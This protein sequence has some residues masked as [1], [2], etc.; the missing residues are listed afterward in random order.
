MGYPMTYQRVL[1]RN[2]L[3]CGDYG[4]LGKCYSSL[5]MPKPFSGNPEASLPVSDIREWAAVNH[6]ALSMLLGDLRRLE[7][8]AVD[9][10]ATCLHI[11]ARTGVDKEVVAAVLKE[12]LSW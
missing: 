9:E 7:G 12:F 8:D 2:R 3:D 5:K 10:A 6:Q 11:A 4:D 1:R